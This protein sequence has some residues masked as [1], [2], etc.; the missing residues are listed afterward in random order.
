LAGLHQGEALVF[1]GQLAVTPRMRKV[2]A[3]LLAAPNGAIIRPMSL[4][5]LEFLVACAAF[6][7]SVPVGVA[8]VAAGTG[9]AAACASSSASPPTP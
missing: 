2:T 9:C 5:A 1:A 3:D 7:L 8:S 4:S 6:R